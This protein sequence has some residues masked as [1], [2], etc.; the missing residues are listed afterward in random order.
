MQFQSLES[1]KNSNVQLQFFVTKCTYSMTFWEWDTL[2]W[3]W[4]H[5]KII[6]MLL[7]MTTSKARRINQW[8]KK[9]INSSHIATF[10]LD[11]SSYLCSECAITT[12]KKKLGKYKYMRWRSVVLDVFSKK[13]R[14]LTLIFFTPR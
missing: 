14:R 13:S 5:S 1:H 11:F 4:K 7:G 10:V 9:K 3:K 2:G 12:Q 6:A 8:V